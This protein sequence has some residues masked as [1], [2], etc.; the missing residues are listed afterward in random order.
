V[1]PSRHQMYLAMA[2]AAS[3]RATCYRLNVGAVVVE[4]RNVVAVGYNGAPS[5]E[6]HCTGNGCQYF[7]VS[8]CKVVHAEINALERVDTDE[9][10]ARHVGLYVTHSP[11]GDCVMAMK[12]AARRGLYVERVFFETAYRDPSP[13]KQL[14]DYG[15]EVYQVMPSGLL[16]NHR[17]GELEQP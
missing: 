1:R 12:L 15:V 17:T 5:G 16:V 8:G 13:I 2:R 6:P 7:T 3:M 14:I 11:C 9:R 10:I 4:G